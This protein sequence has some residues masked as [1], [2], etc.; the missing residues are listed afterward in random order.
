MG[1]GLRRRCREGVLAGRIL[2]NYVVWGNGSVSA[3]LWNAI[4]SDDW[5]IPHVSLSSLGEIV[6]L[7]RP[8]GVPPRNMHTSKGVRPHG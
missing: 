3:R 2:L 6:V 7:G 4:R 8:D 1:H 5:A